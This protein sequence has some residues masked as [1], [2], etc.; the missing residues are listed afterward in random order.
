MMAT[1]RSYRVVVTASRSLRQSSPC[2]VALLAALEYLH[3]VNNGPVPTALITVVHG[4]AI[5]GDQYFKQQAVRLGMRLEAH[6]ISREE[7]A[8]SGPAKGPERNRA[9]LDDYRGCDLVVAVRKGGRR[10]KGTTNC[11]EEARAREKVIIL[12]DLP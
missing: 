6:A 1:T 12:I 8:A 5:Y 9:M 7:W 2:Y 11:I 4:D 10:S 3:L